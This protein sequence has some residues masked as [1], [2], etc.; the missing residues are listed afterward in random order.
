MNYKSKLYLLFYGLIFIFILQAETSAQNVKRVVIIKLDGLP[1]Y[2]VDQ[3]V[4]QKNPTT[5]KSMLPW[6]TEVFYKNGTRVPNFYTRG[7]SL[8]GPSWSLLD[9]GQHLQIKGNTEYDRFSLQAYDYLNLFVFQVK[10]GLK[11]SIDMPGV[12]VLDQLKIPLLSDAYPVENSYTSYQL[13]QRG[14]GFGVMSMGFLK[15]FPANA[16]DFIDEWQMGFNYRNAP[17]KQNEDDI[18][19]KVNKNP[20]ID[21]LDYFNGSFDHISHHNNDRQSR[22]EV[23][24]QL[25]ITIGRIWTAIK[26]SP[27]ADETALF[28]VSDHGFN[29]DEKVYSQGFNIV[30]L[31]ASANGGGHHVITKRR[32]ML[33][34][35]IKGIYPLIPLITT[36]STDSYYLKDQSKDYPTAL[37]DFDGNERSSLHLRNNDLNILQILLQQLQNNKLSLLSQ[38]AAEAAFFEIINRHRAEW[39]KT[40]NLL[41]EEL[42]ALHRWIESQQ[43][44]IKAQPKKWTPEDIAKG[45]NDKAMRV[46][47]QAENATQDEIKYREYL[48][49]LSN[50]LSLK[51]DFF[52]PKE[53][54]IEDYIAHG[55]MG[56]RNSVYNLQ[57]YVVGLSNQGLTLKDNDEIDFEKS[58]KRVNYLDLFKSQNVINNVQAGISNYPIDFIA[59]HIPLDEL[60]SALSN[61]LKPN[62][63]PIWLYDGTDKQ[64]LIL[65]RADKNGNQSFRYLPIANLQQQS[66]GKISFENKEWNT[67]FPLK[68]FEDENLNIPNSDKS[69]W[70][71]SWHSEIEWLR[72]TH[73][74]FYSNGII[75]L[76]EQMD[77]H[78]LI[79]FENSEG[80][81]EDEK[82][83]R[84]FRQFQRHSTAADLLFLANNHWNFDVRGFNPGGNH[85]SFFRVSTNSTL[86]MAGGAKTNIPRGFTVE[87]PYDSLSFVPTVLALT[88]KLN[89]N[90][91]PNS[92]LYKLGFR[93]FPGRIIQEVVK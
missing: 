83:I 52:R 22:I 70:L 8:S 56:T 2:Y 79:G 13:Y 58:F 24:K 87:E 6:I 11:K 92:D 26:Q 49:V 48:R 40:G 44:I 82:L 17:T 46:A 74:T 14:N 27:R 5:G 55:A 28:V 37:V 23:L 29:S 84:R 50:L 18:V 67:G 47:I 91:E 33:D 86:M 63:D 34:Y 7:M 77:D 93:R 64:A 60:S 12:E 68:M 90:N 71:G 19:K 43:P 35:S 42:D 21:Y 54:K 38:R 15:M 3:L 85:G 73:K 45:L 89:A 59:A 20:E 10:Y 65:T 16:D 81:S 30:K 78:P 53:M 88:G 39:T 31:L 57:N 69:A 36:V 75:G 32:L 62:E 51:R 4:K 80:L 61:D 76:N 25:D 72:A 41:N 9:T 1:G 66:D